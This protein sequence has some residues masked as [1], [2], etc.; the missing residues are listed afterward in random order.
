MG[1][2]PVLRLIIFF[3]SVDSSGLNR[4]IQGLPHVKKGRGRIEI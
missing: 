1:D 3:K 4:K 2:V